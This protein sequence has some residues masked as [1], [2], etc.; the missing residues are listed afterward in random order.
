[1]NLLPL[2]RWRELMGYHPLHFWGMSHRTLA[3]SRGQCDS[4]LPQH[5]WQYADATSRDDIARAIEDA[6]S[7]IKSYLGYDVAPRYREQQVPFAAHHET[8]IRYYGAYTNANGGWFSAQLPDGYVQAVGVETM[9]YLGDTDILVQDK[10]GDGYYETFQAAIEIPGDLTD[11]NEVVC[12]PRIATTTDSAGSTYFQ[13]REYGQQTFDCEDVPIAG[14]C[15]DLSSGHDCA[16]CNV[17]TISGKRWQLVEPLRY[18]GFTWNSSTGLD[19]TAAIYVSKL[20]VYRKYVSA[21]GTARDTAQAVL[22][23]ETLPCPGWA[24]T[25]TATDSSTDPAAVGYAIARVGIRDP[26]RGIVTPAAAVYNSTSEVWSSASCLTTGRLPDRVTVRYKAGYPLSSKGLMDSVLEQM[27]IRLSAC[28]L[29]RMI[30]DGCG[31]SI[32][33]SRLSHWQFDL[34]QTNGA[35]GESYGL[36]SAEVLNCPLG[37]R[38]GQVWTW[39]QI[40]NGRV[41]GGVAV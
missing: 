21:G 4:I 37:T 16:G 27:V 17:A 18:E 13:P 11:P 29:T 14:L 39:A 20:A 19:P 30:R 3:P 2:E 26:R 33:N 15:V 31:G 6:E 34:A 35:G 1:M 36:T 22:W 8:G 28:E 10:D 41:T 38:R 12:F 25:D 40:K 23:W 24:C 9:E 32:G 5:S 7:T